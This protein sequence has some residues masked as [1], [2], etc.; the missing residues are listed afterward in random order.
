MGGASYEKWIS[1][2]GGDRWFWSS[3]VTPDTSSAV[4]PLL[5]STRAR[6]QFLEDERARWVYS[7]SAHDMDH[8]KQ[9]I[10]VNYVKGKGDNL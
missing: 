3:S 5:V 2:R 9:I 4:G 6:V 8:P 1:E 10:I 7:C